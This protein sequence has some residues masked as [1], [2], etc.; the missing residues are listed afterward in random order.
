MV[1]TVDIMVKLELIKHFLE[2]FGRLAEAEV[3]TLEAIME[4]LEQMEAV[5]QAEMVHQ[6]EQV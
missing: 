6:E 4:E 1:V 5:A 3:V 2:M